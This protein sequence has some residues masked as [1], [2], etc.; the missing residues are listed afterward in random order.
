MLLQRIARLAYNAVS[1]LILARYLGPAVFGELSYALSLAAIV[2]VLIMIVADTVLV[3]ELV[4]EEHEPSEV[5]ST[6]F[7]LRAVASLLM[8]LVVA[9][10]AL[11]GDLSEQ[12]RHYQ[13][14]ISLTVLFKAF[15]V[16]EVH[17]Q[18]MVRSKYIAIANSLQAIVSL[19][20]ILVFVMFE[21]PPRQVAWLFVCDAAMLGAAQSVVL[22]RHGGPGI[23]WVRPA[24]RLS[25]RMMV[26]SLPLLLSSISVVLYVRVDQVMLMHLSTASELGRFTV[27]ART[28]E[29][30]YFIPA[31]ITASYYPSMLRALDDSGEALYRQ[32][33][34]LLAVLLALSVLTSVSLSISAHFGVELV[35]GPAYQE[36]AGILSVLAFSFIFVCIG[37]VMTTISIVLGNEYQVLY[38]TM[39]GALIN[40][41]LN[42]LFIPHYGA[43]AAAWTSLVSYAMSGYLLL[44][45]FRQDRHLFHLV[46]SAIRQSINGSLFR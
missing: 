7:A 27:A 37:S 23:S 39:I 33:R 40:I 11:V 4:N 5:L 26:A 30:L 42:W 21:L 34:R 2:V 19:I 20:L 14:V 24:W 3:R 25:R 22:V 16:I 41:V 15:T 38:R 18:A 43:M 9:A 32:G 35:F 44:L 8:T 29:I 1:L 36:S 6:G 28:S 13:L 12:A 45:L 31:A 10:L 17:F 46:P